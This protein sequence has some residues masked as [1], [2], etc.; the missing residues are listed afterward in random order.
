MTAAASHPMSAFPRERWRRRG[1]MLQ[2]ALLVCISAVFLY[3]HATRVVADGAYGS[4]PFAVEQALLVWMFLTRRRSVATST[5]VF[6]WLAATGGGWLPFFL[7][8]QDGLPAA[9]EIIGTAVQVAGLTCTIICFTYLGKSFG[10]VA[11]NRGLKT[12]GPYGL[13]RHPIYVSHSIT[14]TGFLIAN[15][16]PVNV[17]M[18]AV[19]TAC[20][21]LRIRAEERVLTDTADYAAYRAVV[22]W[23]LLPGVF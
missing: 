10:I 7:Q 13:V 16:H 21:L 4:V 19:I 23:R 12:H 15:F 3:V 14:M 6:D 2:D 11:A 20:Q 1:S 18:L 22:R 9:A 5:R 17:A 8:P